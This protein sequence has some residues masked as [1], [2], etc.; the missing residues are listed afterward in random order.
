MSVDSVFLPQL[1]TENT[2]I[3]DGTMHNNLMHLFITGIL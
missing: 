3:K 1:W 2:S